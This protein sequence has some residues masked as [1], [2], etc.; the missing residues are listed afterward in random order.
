MRLMASG[1]GDT[2]TG[3]LTPVPC[4]YTLP[5]VMDEAGVKMVP[6][7]LIEEQGWAVDMHEL[8]RALKTAR[9]RC[10][11]RAIYISNPGNPT[12]K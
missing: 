6:Y 12:G 9:G 10:E 2:R 11:P 3:I 5:P 8:H 1:E 7:Q 4:P